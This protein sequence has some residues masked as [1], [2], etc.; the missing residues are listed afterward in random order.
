MTTLLLARHGETDW[1][2]QRKW[3]GRTGSPLNETGRRQAA[4]LAA[5]LDGIDAEAHLDGTDQAR[6]RQ[7]LETVGNCALVEVVVRARL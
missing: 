4:V 5:R 7:L 6:A 2:L 1:N 3:Q